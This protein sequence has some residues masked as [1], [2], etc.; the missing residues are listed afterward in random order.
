MA[1]VQTR[2][3]LHS[4]TKHPVRAEAAACAD[5]AMIDQPSTSKRGDVML[6]AVD[7]EMVAVLHWHAERDQLQFTAVRLE[8]AAEPMAFQRKPVARETTRHLLYQAELPTDSAGIPI[9]LRRAC[10]PREAT[11]VG[12]QWACLVTVTMR[13]TTMTKAA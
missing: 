11:A 10:R 1:A 2:R 6:R 13:R 9:H 4:A 5:H 12:T 3:A 8:W 7:D